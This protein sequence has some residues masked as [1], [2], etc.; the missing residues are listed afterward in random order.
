VNVRFIASTNRDPEEAVAA[1]VLREDLYYRL[2]VVPIHL[3]PL[4]ERPGDIPLLADHFLSRYW[5]R[6]R[7][8]G[9]PVPKFGEGAIRALRA[10]PWKGNVRELQN[11]IEH[12]VVLLDPA[13]EIRAEDIP[14]LPLPALAGDRGLDLDL[15]AAAADASY[16]DA[17]D[18]LLSTFDREFLTR[19]I[20]YAGGNLSKAARRAGI[21]RTTFYRLMERHGLQ[22]HGD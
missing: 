20:A 2:R 8:T 21:D 10:R 12:M 16:Y 14:F 7:E 9:A 19:A 6:H 22:R 13:A 18:R 5:S 4:R 17:R 1:G 15:T 11:V 3:P